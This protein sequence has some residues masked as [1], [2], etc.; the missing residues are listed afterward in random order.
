[1]A[2]SWIRLAKHLLVSAPDMRLLVILGGFSGFLIGIVTGW[3]CHAPLPTIVWRAS[4]AAL[5]AGVVLRWWGQVWMQG[6][7]QAQQQKPAAPAPAPAP[8]APAQAEV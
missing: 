5:L 3:A 8:T 4:V 1:M 7:E 2:I 6:L